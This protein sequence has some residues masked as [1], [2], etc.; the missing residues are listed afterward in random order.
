M[1]D[2][3]A[4]QAIV[5]LAK[6]AAEEEG[7]ENGSGFFQDSLAAPFESPEDALPPSLHFD[8]YIISLW[9]AAFSPTFISMPIY[10]CPP[11]QFERTFLHY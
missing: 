11:S 8:D 7:S 9:R 6:P 4:F 2:F 1:K 10:F 3:L 5:E